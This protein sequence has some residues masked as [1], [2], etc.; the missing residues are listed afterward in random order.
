[1]NFADLNGKTALVTGGNRGIGKQIA[2]T[3][4]QA[5]A[6]VMITGSNEAVLKE[7]AL[8]IGA[9]FAVADLSNE[10]GVK[11][12]LAAALEKFPD[13]V[14]ILV[15]NAGYSEDGLLLRQTPDQLEKIMQINFKSAVSL[16][17]GLLQKMMKKRQGRIINITSVVAHMGNSGQTAYVSSKAAL[18]GFTK[19][20]AKEVAKRGITVNAVAPGFIETAMTAELPEKVVEEYKAGIAAARFGTPQEVANAVRYLASSEAGYVTGTTLHVNGGLYL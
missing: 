4:R 14:D 3:L 11:S 6:D 19:A 17:R 10:D 13:G 1:M 20:L 5:G 8:E 7:A 12:L 9:G 18:T 15:N 2:I 16:S